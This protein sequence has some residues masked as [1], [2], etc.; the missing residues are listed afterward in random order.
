MTR[1]CYRFFARSHGTANVSEVRPTPSPHFSPRGCGLIFG[2]PGRPEW[3]RAARTGAPCRSKR[4]THARLGVVFSTS[5]TVLTYALRGTF[6]ACALR[7]LARRISVNSVVESELHRRGSDAL[8]QRYADTGKT[9]TARP[10][11]CE[12]SRGFLRRSSAA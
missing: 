12:P 5:A 9:Q 2:G 4:S 3:R 11:P 8:A 10:T 7:G 6:E 1:R